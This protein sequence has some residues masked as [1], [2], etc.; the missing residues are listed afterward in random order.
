MLAGDYSE[1]RAR[2]KQALELFSQLNTRRQIGRALF[3]LG[4]LAAAQ[5]DIA[6]ARDYFF[7]ALAEFET[8]QA[9][10]DAAQTR[11]RLET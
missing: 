7:R 1:A 8:M 6:G 10:S 2:L 3:E 4:E 5:G 11:V 9:A